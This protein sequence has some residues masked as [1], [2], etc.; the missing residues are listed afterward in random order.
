MTAFM[1]THLNIKKKTR[2]EQTN[3]TSITYDRVPP[4]YGPNDCDITDQPW[5]WP[6][7]TYNRCGSSSF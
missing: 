6:V 2:K 5:T 4:H 1:N 7:D 3:K